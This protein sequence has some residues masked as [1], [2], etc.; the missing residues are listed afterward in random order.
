MSG[1]EW[2]GRDAKG[3]CVPAGLYIAYVK[4]GEEKVKVTVRIVYQD[5]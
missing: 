3:D 2:Y 4:A 5:F 1:Y